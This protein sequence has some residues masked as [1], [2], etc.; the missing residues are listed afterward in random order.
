M[1]TK[2]GWDFPADLVEAAW[3]IIANSYGG[4]WDKATPDWR[5][6]AERWRDAYYETLPSGD[7]SKLADCRKNPSEGTV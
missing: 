1:S 5:E 7:G 4:D 3:G 6:A 2:H